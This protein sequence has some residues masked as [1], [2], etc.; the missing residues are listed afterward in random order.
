MYLAEER[1]DYIYSDSTH[2]T[3]TA[4]HLAQQYRLYKAGLEIA[5]LSFSTFEYDHRNVTTLVEGLLDHDFFTQPSRHIP[6]PI[7]EKLAS[8]ETAFTFLYINPNM[9]FENEGNS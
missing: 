9:P 5:N 2:T 4:S 7:D 3:R 6:L 8:Y 1:L